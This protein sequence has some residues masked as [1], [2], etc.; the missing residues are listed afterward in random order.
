MSSF[1]RHASIVAIAAA[2]AVPATA[3]A[4]GTEGWTFGASL[5]G[6]FPSLSG[7]SNFPASGSGSSVSID[8]DRILDNLEFVFMGSFEARKGRWGGFTDLIYMDIGTDRSGSRDITIGGIG[9]PASAS[10]D[11]NYDIKGLIWT[12]AGEYN[13]HATREANV[14]VFAGARLVDLEQDIRWNLNGNIG[15]VPVPGR[16]GGSNVSRSN[17]D[18]IVGV[19]GRLRFGQEQRWFVPYYLDVGT[20]DSDFTW[21]AQA[22]VGYTWGW[23]DVML[24]WRHLDYDFGSGKP[25]TDL[26]LSGPQLGVNFR[27]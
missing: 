14:D 5:Y 1:T 19:K 20:G 22:G 11:I 13:V 26:S 3:S 10:A 27:W 17:W 16:S 21:Q 24:G 6:Y 2:L 23:G 7:T 18:G 15:S 4:Q 12:I 25:F 8:V 9:L